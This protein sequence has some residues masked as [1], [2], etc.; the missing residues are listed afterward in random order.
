MTRPPT[1][2]ITLR[3]AIE[4]VDVITVCTIAVS[5]VIRASTSPVR[6]VSYQAGGKV[7]RC[8]NTARRTSASTR[9]PIWFTKVAKIAAGSQHQRD[10]RSADHRPIE[11]RRI[12][13][14]SPSSTR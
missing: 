5:V 9:S 13:R 8:A 1:S 3:A 6:A 12:C 2:R 7:I 14:P 10:Q 11:Q 4:M